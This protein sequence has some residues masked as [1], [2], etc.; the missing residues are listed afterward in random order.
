MDARRR[1]TVDAKA[2]FV[3]WGKGVK[4]AVLIRL[5]AKATAGI[6]VILCVKN[7]GY[8]MGWGKLGEW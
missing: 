4:A 7:I 3:L 5:R 2:A 1:S 6:Q 8:G